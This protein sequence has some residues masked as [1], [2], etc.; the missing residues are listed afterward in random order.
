MRRLWL[1]PVLASAAYSAP[2]DA[3]RQVLAARC[4]ACHAQTAVGGLRLD[5]RAAMLQGG[6]SG[7]AL[8]PGDP[9]RSRLMQAIR[10]D[11]PGVKAMPPG[12]PL[13]EAERRVV[14]DWIAA[15]AP[16][17][18]DAAHWAFQPLRPEAAGFAI[19]PLI[20]TALRA[21]G[22][23]ANP[24]ADRRTLIRRLYFDLTGLPPTATEFATAFNDASEG[25][26]ARLTDRL[27][28]SPHFGEQWGRHWLDVARY[29][30]DD[31]SGTAVIP[32]PNAWRYR[33][34]V[35]SA[36]NQ[37]L[38]YDRF[39]MAQLAG[40]LMNDPALLPATGLLGLGP[41]YYG[42]AQPA[43][44][45]ADERNDRVD[46]V[47]RGMLGVTVAC[48]R[49]HD[50]KYDP[51]SQK[52]Y[53]ALAGVFASS[54]YKEYPLVPDAQVADWKGRKKA[55]D[56]AEK[57]L[58]KFLDDHGT[59]LAE[60]YAPQISR[61]MMATVD[62]S[63]AKDLPPKL[64]ER[65]KKY[66]AQPEEFHPFLKA[67]FDGR[68]TSAEAD[69]FQ[70]LLIGILA[71]K[72]AL[73][74]ENKVAVE[75]AK[76]LEPRVIKT[77]TLPGGYRSEEDFNPGAYIAAKS[78]ERDRFVAW[79]RTFGEASAPLKLPRELVPEFLDAPQKAEHR[80]LAQR[81][82]E[83]KKALPPQ[84]GFLQGAAEFE[85][86]DL[87]LNL[88]GNPEALGDVVPRHFPPALSGGTGLPLQQGS[89]RMQLAETVAHHPLAARVAANRVW[90]SLF[91]QGLVRT[92]SNFGRVGDR[93]AIPELLEQLAS[94]LVT[95]KYSIKALIR[96][97]V[98][99]DAYQRSSAGSR[100]GDAVDPDN[101]YLWR[102]NRR[103]LEAEPLRDAMLTVSGELD[104]R[105]GGAS[106][107]LTA[108]LPRRTL[109]GKTSRFQPDETLS[110]FDLPAAAVTCEQ[111]VVTNV[112]LQKLFYLNS[113]AVHRRAAAVGKLVARRN[114]EK[115]IA[116]AY[117]LL[118]HREP[119]PREQA[120]GLAFLGRSGANA[121]AQYAQ[122]LLS[123]NEFAYVD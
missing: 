49:C 43:Q 26:L 60:S 91:G 110:L 115:G 13:T 73:D 52:D 30:E 93:P 21:K 22:L 53:Y 92:P 28:A 33:D 56:E 64:V 25:W 36:L 94:R 105:V 8:V 104:R 74:A 59:R 81:L 69:A 121:W 45:R 76:K 19:D 11:V 1:I 17:K 50:H 2:D 57:A 54:A 117:R 90:M 46:M 71:E 35:V 75:A 9:S 40:D 80:K 10:R 51:I 84:Y 58:N 112:P 113:D 100:A 98:L 39:L 12:A 122:V 47:T 86:E 44:S 3:A 62:P 61:Y 114:R 6:P 27:L 123:S 119:T 72:K 18:D 102:Q 77:I 7:P 65:W 107:P 95:H 63:P 37:D 85:P 14:E 103:R 41:W 34:W 38:P 116:A 70:T 48:A 87:R 89:G 55:V 66:L 111:R 88:R 109:Y 24:A 83:L 29:G 79:N 120:L 97:I 31:Y 32:Y 4:W 20:T 101:R 78:L 67:W 118:L 42:I 96:E 106:A 108:S 16:W 68:K 23:P 82:A 5:S 99:S 15:G